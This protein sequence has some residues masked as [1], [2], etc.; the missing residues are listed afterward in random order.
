MIRIPAPAIATGLLRNSRQKICQGERSTIGAPGPESGST[1]T[2]TAR[3]PSGAAAP[4]EVDDD[5]AAPS[6]T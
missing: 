6:R 3:P 4:I 5:I 1:R 2:P